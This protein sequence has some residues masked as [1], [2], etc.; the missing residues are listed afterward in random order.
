MTK[1]VQ[2]HGQANLKPV[3]SQEKPTLPDA[4]FISPEDAAKILATKNTY[5]R[6]FKPHKI[7]IYTEDMKNGEW[8]VRS[9]SC[10]AYDREGYLLNGQNRLQAV[11]NS[12]LGQ[13]FLVMYNMTRKEVDA[14]DNGAPR[15]SVDA[16]KM[17]LK[18][19]GQEV[20]KNLPER[21]AVLNIVNRVVNVRDVSGGVAKPKNNMIQG[22]EIK[23]GEVV[24]TAITTMK[25]AKF[26][27]FKNSAPIK[28]ALAVAS[29]KFGDKAY[30]FGNC[31]AENN[32]NQK[33]HPGLSD[34]YSSIQNSTTERR[35]TGA[36]GQGDMLVKVL[37]AVR[38]YIQGETSKA[39]R[40]PTS[41][42]GIQELISF[43]VD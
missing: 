20:P 7:A 37:T 9:G 15:S 34:F 25:K 26:K 30:E 33:T 11:V 27:P 35:N 24:S 42:E 1:F 2:K 43:F 14:M 5:N 4:V 40:R 8:Y 32:F 38:N 18:L 22:L 3:Q 21:H 41:K 36:A 31:L 39:V 16:E 10:L 17:R 13:W 23:Y 6:D 12:N 29:I 28:G 19:L